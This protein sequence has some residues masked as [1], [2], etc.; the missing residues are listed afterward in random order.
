[1]AETGAAIAAVTCPHRNRYMVD[2]LHLL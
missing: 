1:M 2:K